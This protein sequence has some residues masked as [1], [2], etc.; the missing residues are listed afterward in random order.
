LKG[1]QAPGYVVLDGGIGSELQFFRGVNLYSG[2]G[3]W[4]ADAIISAPQV[5]KQIHLEYYSVGADVATTATFSA[6]LDGF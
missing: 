2:S 3:L 5:I 4:D 6:H 1:K